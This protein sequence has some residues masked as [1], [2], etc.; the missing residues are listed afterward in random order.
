MAPDAYKKSTE[1]VRLRQ[2]LSKHAGQTGT[3]PT[4][5]E[6]IIDD[7]LETTHQDTQLRF[8]GDAINEIVGE[9]PQDRFHTEDSF[10]SPVVRENRRQDAVSRYFRETLHFL[11]EDTPKEVFK[12]VLGTLLLELNFAHQ[13]IKKIGPCDDESAEER[14]A[15]TLHLCYHD[16]I[17]YLGRKTLP[18]SLGDSD[19]AN[20][21][22]KIA[23]EN[24][25]TDDIP[26]TAKQ[27]SDRD[28][29]LV[30]GL[31]VTV[32]DLIRSD[33]F[34]ETTFKH[35]R[36]IGRWF[37]LNNIDQITD[38][39]GEK[40][41]NPVELLYG[42]LELRRISVIIGK[43]IRERAL[44]E[45]IELCYVAIVT[46]AHMKTRWREAIINPMKQRS[47]SDSD[48]DT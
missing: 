3:V 44:D 32:D 13:E 43:T 6:S 20:E 29:H 47:A 31:V 18:Y 14:Q 33:K 48:E 16:R 45:P 4:D 36:Q 34:G 46:Q 38:E 22:D 2:M 27:I 30:R 7:V 40:Y 42:I 19:E 12:S 37:N 17:P 28:D 25:G 39:Y 26:C 41:R 21:R 10:L 35:L 8:D 11:P 1:V 9:A 15:H 23:C 24:G 5:S